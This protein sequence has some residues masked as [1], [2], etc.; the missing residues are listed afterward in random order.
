M[1]KLTDAE[2]NTIGWSIGGTIIFLG[3]IALIV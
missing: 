3:V 2:K 1:R